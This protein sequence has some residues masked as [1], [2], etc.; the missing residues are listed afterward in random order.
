[1]KLEDFIK[2]HRKE[3]DNLEPSEQLWTKL[4]KKLAQKTAKQIRMI[5]LNRVW[6]AAAA[7]LLFFGS[8]MW[9]QWYYLSG[10]GSEM[11]DKEEVPAKSSQPLEQ[12]NPELAETELFYNS[13]IAQMKE[14]VNRSDFDDAEVLQEFNTDLKDVEN[15]YGE[16]KN[17][18]YESGNDQV[19]N[20]MIQNLQLQVE[21]LNRQIQML[22]KIRRIKKGGYKNE[23]EI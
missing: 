18:L 12:I 6:W 2:R 10:Q 14:I 8:A 5:P 9:F 13:Q 11:A 1:M 22:E 15:R 19:V 23:T 3:M 7:F 17:E 4:E 20:A 21:M 16:L